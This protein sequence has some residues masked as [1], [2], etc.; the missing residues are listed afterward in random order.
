M[1]GTRPTRPLGGQIGADGAPSGSSSRQPP[2]RQL[3]EQLPRRLPGRQPAPRGGGGSV[4]RLV[5]G[6]GELLI[7]VGFVVAL[8]VVYELWV[9]DMVQERTQSR[10]RSELSQQWAAAAP[11]GLPQPR[12]AP[13]AVGDGVAVLR[14]PRFGDGYAPVV[15]EGVSD[16]ALRRGPGHYPGT[17]WPGEPGNFVV[18]G[19]R[20]TYGHPFSRLDEL[21]IGDQVVV[22]VRDH[23]FVYRVTGSEVVDPARTD[24]ILP[25]PGQPGARPTKS[26]LTFTTCNPKY[27]ASTR[28]IVF[29]E[30][31][32]TRP[33]TPGQS[34]GPARG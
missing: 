24:V 5:R 10:L 1:V 18:S 32:G 27:S 19:H 25:V 14:I 23:Y 9:T 15:V 20:T 21:R 12:L 26:L 29:G 28:L 22:E 30:L 7:T 4:G 3:P 16:G 6:V 34:L 2:G 11:A 31:T 33:K 13:T 8:F 17:A